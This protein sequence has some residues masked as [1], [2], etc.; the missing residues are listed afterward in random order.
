MKIELMLSKAQMRAAAGLSQEPDRQRLN[1]VFLD[2]LAGR[3]VITSHCASCGEQ[4]TRQEMDR[5]FCCS[6]ECGQKHARDLV[7]EAA[8]IENVA[9]RGRKKE[10]WQPTNHV[11]GPLV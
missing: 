5:D 8:A 2:L 4:F 10:K 9:A 6:T 11:G 3:E 1:K 7:R